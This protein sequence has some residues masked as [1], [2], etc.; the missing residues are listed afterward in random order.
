[1]WGPWGSRLFLQCVG[2]GGEDDSNVATPLYDQAC[3]IHPYFPECY[4]V[5]AFSIAFY[6][7]PKLMGKEKYQITIKKNLHHHTI[8][9][10]TSS[11]S[12][13]SKDGNT[14]CFSLFQRRAANS[15]GL[16]LSCPLIDVTQ[17][18]ADLLAIV[19]EGG[20]SHAA[21]GAMKQICHTCF[22]RPV[23]KG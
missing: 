1:M 15:L 10:F 23:R 21:A 7:N 12:P 16:M 5:Q 2:R 14:I 6:I 20:L 19:I 4:A 13:F 18:R 17:K 8:L 9:S 11:K 22:E 3:C